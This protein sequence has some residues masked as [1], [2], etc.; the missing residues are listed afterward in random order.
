[1]DAKDTARLSFGR[2]KQ[3]DDETVFV[4]DVI[5]R[6]ACCAATPTKFPVP[7]DHDLRKDSSGL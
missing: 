4:G 1:M 5:Y 6:G 3:L 7:A 2:Q